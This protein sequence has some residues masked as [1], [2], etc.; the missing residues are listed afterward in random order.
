M[1]AKA[2][3]KRLNESLRNFY[4]KSKNIKVREP[5]GTILLLDRGFDLI[6]PVIH[7][8]FYESIVY[9]YKDV[10]DEGEVQVGAENKTAFLNDQDELWVRFRSKHIAEVHANL[11]EEVSQVA[12][13]SKK[14]VGKNTQDMS[15]TE[16]AEVIRS[17]P[18]YEEMMKKYQ[19][20]MELINKGIT[21]F[22]SNNLRK[23]IA[24]EQ[25]IISGV[26]GKGNKINNT[27]VVKDIS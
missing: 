3:A 2:L 21:D 11:N 8:Y 27:N 25:D 14:K 12:S 9:E 13:E 10:G 6:A 5:R 23:L 19:V 15:L 20:H 4:E 26:D 1:I 17:M 7:D 16:M 22:T 24:L 18:K